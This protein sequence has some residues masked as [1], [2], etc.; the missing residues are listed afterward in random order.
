MPLNINYYLA[1]ISSAS[2]LYSII[3]ENTKSQLYETEFNNDSLSLNSKMN[4]SSSISKININNSLVDDLVLEEEKEGK[5]DFQFKK[6]L[7][8]KK[9][10]G[11]AEDDKLTK[12]STKHNEV[13]YGTKNVCVNKQKYPISCKSKSKIKLPISVTKNSLESE[14]VEGIIIIIINISIYIK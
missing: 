12:D 7:S 10:E 14:I 1:S 4:S 8:S 13:P 3:S 11:L 6:Y 2:V 9:T 5:E